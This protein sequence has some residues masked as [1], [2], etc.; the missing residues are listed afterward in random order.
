MGGATF[1]ARRVI[2]INWKADSK[3]PAAIIADAAAGRFRRCGAQRILAPSDG[4]LHVPKP[5]PPGPRSREVP[6]YRKIA[7]ATLAATLWFPCTDA[8]GVAQRTFVSAS[9]GADANA[10]VNCG[11]AN[12][13]RSFGTAM[14]VTATN[15]EIVVL[16][17]G[18]Y[19]RVTID[20]SVTIAAPSGVYAGISVFP[21][22]NGIDIL[23]DNVT[24]VL[25]GL[26]INGQGGVNGVFVDAANV[27]LR[28]EN[29]VIANLVKDTIIRDNRIGMIVT[30]G[31]VILG[32]LQVEGSTSYGIWLIDVQGSLSEST[33]SRNGVYGVRVDS[34]SSG[35]AVVAISDTV[36]TGNSQDGVAAYSN[37]S[38]DALLAITRSTISANGQGGVV[39]LPGGTGAVRVEVTDSTVKANAFSG[40]AIVRLGGAAASVITATDNLVSGNGGR[41][42]LAS[43]TEIYAI[44]SR[45]TITM[46]TGVGLEQQSSAVV[47]SSVDN[48]VRG[49]NSGLAQTAGTI[50]PI[51]GL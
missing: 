14:T 39:A 7:T 42:I 13:C 2:A 15:G 41:G 23:T 22:F 3:D 6:M 44:A 17:S 11:L 12:P 32:R 28:V 26:T 25:R 8:L 49:N 19:G 30:G 38:S 4:R 36:I 40:L 51:T 9:S 18:G 31:R 47:E 1:G 45:N 29:C 27:R 37:G 16:D 10:A 34:S 20:K 24:V 21:G 5:A 33:S 50:T 43:G 35:D 46:N 48:V